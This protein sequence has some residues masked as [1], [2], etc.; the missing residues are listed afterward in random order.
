MLEMD[1][2]DPAAVAMKL[3]LTATRL[4]DRM[5]ETG[6]TQEDLADAVGAT[7]GAISQILTGMT[8]RSRLLPA[9]ATFLAVNL[10]WLVGTSD[11][12]IEMFDA[13][14]EDISEDDLALIRAGRS[15]K[16]LLK[17][18][19]LE[20]KP[21]ALVT[22]HVPISESQDE[23]DE[24]VDVMEI[25]LA[26]GMGGGGYLELPVKKKPRRFTRGW[27]RLFTQAP[28]SQIFIAQGIGDSMAPTIQNADIVI[29]DTSDT[30]LT[31]GD[32]IWAAAYG[33][34]GVIKRLLPMP[35]GGVKIKSDN[36]LVESEMAYDGELHVIGKV[37]AVV[38]KMSGL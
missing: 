20:A 8:R 17:P 2:L 37:V 4:R 9:I 13:D 24:L 26:F 34:T 33:Q 22:S 3:P 25:D 7:Q 27:L 18:E 15:D 5:L 6:T 10:D 1:A 32:Q 36:P 23:D 16:R 30:R 19:Q 12:M 31:M 38:R 14:G 29:I 35:N 11:Q 28:P 21:T